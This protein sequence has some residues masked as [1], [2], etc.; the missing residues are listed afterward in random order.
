V[1]LEGL[2][3]E[4]LLGSAEYLSVL[5]EAGFERAKLVVSALRIEDANDLLAYRC[6]SAGVRCAVHVV[7]I[8]VVD[9]LLELD[10]AYLMIPKVDGVKL[11]LKVLREMEVLKP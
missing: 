9:N 3:G 6:Q 11:Q 4:T 5:Q 2:P 8:S 10:A 1:K 7:D